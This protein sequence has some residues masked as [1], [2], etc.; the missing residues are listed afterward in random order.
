MDPRRR[1]RRTVRDTGLILIVVGVIAFLLSFAAKA[2][3][4]DN[5]VRTVPDDVTC[6]VPGVV[7]LVHLPPGAKLVPAPAWVKLDAEIKRLQDVETTRIA[8]EAELER[9][10]VEH[11][12]QAL[13]GAGTVGIVVGF[14]VGW[15]V[16]PQPGS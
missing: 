3:E 15:I 8:R 12:V 6:R 11:L 5:G 2:E 10:Y 4:P 1:I 7:D 14:V 13:T 16:K 9:Q